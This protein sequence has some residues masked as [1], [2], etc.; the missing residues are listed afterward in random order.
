MSQITWTRQTGIGL[1]VD[2]VEEVAEVGG[3]MPRGQLPDHLAGGDVER[4]EQV[5]GAV[6][7]NR[8]E[9]AQRIR[10]DAVVA[11]PLP[12]S[13]IAYDGLRRR[14]RRPIEPVGTERGS[15]IRPARADGCLGHAQPEGG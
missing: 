12:E 15:G 9:R 4:G 3:R 8:R 2:L 1:A 11:E 14:G 13:A 6:I 5:V 10:G 7:A